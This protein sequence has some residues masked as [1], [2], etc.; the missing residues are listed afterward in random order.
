ML[1]SFFLLSGK[2]LIREV[3]RKLDSRRH[4]CLQVVDLEGQQVG[5]ILHGHKKFMA[6]KSSTFEAMFYGP[7]KED[8]EPIVI[9]ETTYE[10]FKNMLNFLHD[11]VEDWSKVELPK[12]LHTANLAERFHLPQMKM[13]VQENI[14]NFTVTKENLLETAATAEE[15]SFL[16]LESK[17]LLQA[18][19]SCLEEFLITPGDLQKFTVEMSAKEDKQ[20]MVGIRLL[21]RVKFANLVFARVFLEASNEE[22]VTI[23]KIWALVKK[24]EKSTNTRCD[25]MKLKDLLD[26][27]VNSE[28]NHFSLIEHLEKQKF[29]KSLTQSLVKCID[30]D[31]LTAG[32]QILA[33]VVVEGS[34]TNMHSVQVHLDLIKII[35]DESRNG[36]GVWINFRDVNNLLDS[37]VTNTVPEVRNVFFD[38]LANNDVIDPD[39]KKKV[40]AKLVLYTGPRYDSYHRLFAAISGE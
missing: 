36:G 4:L 5:Q 26:E 21:A 13:K 2:L 20:G 10:A 17:A 8:K 39:D 14:E 9:K 1:L 18:C 19:S 32:N 23:W 37:I 16:S 38:W 27:L 6:Y 15:F 7:L 29:I 33:E 40:V 25:L 11:I 34:I 24:T 3:S 31:K 12:L 30:M 35:Q 22:M 28:Y